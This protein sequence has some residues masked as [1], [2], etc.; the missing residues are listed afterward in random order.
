MPIS[1]ITNDDGEPMLNATEMAKIFKKDARR[2]FAN[3]STFDYIEAFATIKGFGATDKI[4]L[5]LNTNTL[6]KRYPALI[7]VVKGGDQNITQ[8]GIFLSRYIAIEFARWLSPMFAVWCDERIMEYLQF[9]F[10]ASEDVLLQMQ[11]DPDYAKKMAEEL[12]AE[13][14]KSRALEQQNTQLL[15]EAEENRPKVNFYDNV[16]EINRKAKKQKT[17]TI[18]RVGSML[19]AN[20]QYLNKLLINNK[21]IMRVDNGYAV[22]PNYTEA[23]IAIPKPLSVKSKREKYDDYDNYDG[24]VEEEPTHQQYLTYTEA[25]IKVIKDLLEQNPPPQLK[26]K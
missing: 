18:T 1:F 11:S 16:Q 8:Q 22:H 19:K 4:P 17:Y 23:D 2:W 9:G 15:T 7:T 6:A 10:T 3:Q 5:S 20:P 14:E 26:K 25:G 24:Y 13:R 12:S 21:V